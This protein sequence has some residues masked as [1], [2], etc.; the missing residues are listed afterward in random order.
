MASVLAGAGP[1]ARRPARPGRGVVGPLGPARERL[2]PARCATWRPSTGTGRP[3]RV[4]WLGDANL[5]PGRRV[6]ARRSAGERSRPGRRSLAY[7]TSENG[8]ADVTGMPAGTD[9]GATQQLADAIRIAAAGRHLPARARSW[10]RWASAT[11]WSR[12]A[13]PPGPS[14]TGPTVEPTGPAHG[15]RRPARPVQ[16]RGGPG[17]RRLPQRGLRARAGA[18]AGR[19]RVPQRGPGVGRADRARPHRGADRAARPARLPVLRRVTAPTPPR[20]TSAE[21]SSSRWQLQVDGA[22]PTR[23]EVLGWANAFDRGGR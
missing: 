18:A 1:G 17:R 21:A 13:T 4:L 14:S 10:P 2:R 5:L 16:R 23:Q 22:P 15:A 12:R 9:D 3:F 11:W 7:A 20:C 8:M 19:H 6:G